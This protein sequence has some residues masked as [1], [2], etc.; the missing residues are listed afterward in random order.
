MQNYLL[1]F[2]HRNVSSKFEQK[3]GARRKGNENEGRRSSVTYELINIPLNKLGSY[4]RSRKLVKWMRWVRRMRQRTSSAT[5]LRLWQNFK[6]EKRFSYKKGQEVAAFCSKTISLQKANF[7]YSK[8]LSFI[9]SAKK[10]KKKTTPPH[11]KRKQRNSEHD[12]NRKQWNGVKVKRLIV[13]IARK[14]I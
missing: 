10:K 12:G 7:S 8:S 14:Q 1:H 11:K 9:V 5:M 3:I 13:A 4:P 2:A 6:C